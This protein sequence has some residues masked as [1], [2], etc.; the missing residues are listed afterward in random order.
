MPQYWADL[1]GKRRS[2]DL[3]NDYSGAGAMDLDLDLDRQP[4]Q[5]SAKRINF[6]RQRDPRGVSI[7]QKSKN[8][9]FLDFPEGTVLNEHVPPQVNAIFQKLKE[10]QKDPEDHLLKPKIRTRSGAWFRQGEG[11][12]WTKGC[13]GIHNYRNCPKLI[14]YLQRH[15]DM[16][17]PMDS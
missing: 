2:T 6:K 14:N 16:Q 9:S 15:P 5:R 10:Q 1:K 4:A 17:A 7:G 11:S 3:N 13:K 12:C 8:S